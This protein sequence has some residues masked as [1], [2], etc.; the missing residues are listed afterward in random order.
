M[1]QRRSSGLPLSLFSS[2]LLH[3]LRSTRD[4]RRRTRLGW[5]RTHTHTPERGYM[6]PPRGVTDESSARPANCRLAA[7]QPV[8][9]T[10][11]LIPHLVSSKTGGI[12]CYRTQSG[13]A[14][15]PLSPGS[16]GQPA[17]RPWFSPDKQPFLRA[18][19]R[20]LSFEFFWL[21][22]PAG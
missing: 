10:T 11:M 20:R 4:P 1:W 21:L 6:T 5:S 2:F 18:S 16:E 8:G 19:S 14:H 12:C 13:S 7:L 3:R 17:I 22:A 9:Q 15:L